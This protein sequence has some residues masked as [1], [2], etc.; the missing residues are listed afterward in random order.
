[1]AY[2]YGVDSRLELIRPLVI[3]DKKESDWT[4]NKNAKINQVV[5]NLPAFNF[6]Q[7]S[8]FSARINGIYYARNQF[9]VRM[10]CFFG[11]FCIKYTAKDNVEFRVY[12]ETEDETVNAA[13]RLLNINVFFVKNSLIVNAAHRLL[14]TPV[15][16]I[17]LNSQWESHLSIQ[18]GEYKNGYAVLHVLNN[19]PTLKS[20][21]IEKII[22]AE[23]MYSIAEQWV[24]SQKTNEELVKLGNTERIVKA[25]FDLKLSFRPNLC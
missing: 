24:R 14:N 21:G 13:H 20:T 16:E 25:G 22:S 11:R 19:V 5:V 1:M 8:L 17:E 10:L 7:P 4:G 23:E 6:Q 18:F 12:T 2:I 15:F 3:T 9:S